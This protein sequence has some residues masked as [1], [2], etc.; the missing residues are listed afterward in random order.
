M[1]KKAVQTTRTRLI[2]DKG[3]NELEI[4]N[5]FDDFLQIYKVLLRTF[6]F[7]YY[8]LFFFSASFTAI[9]ESVF[10]IFVF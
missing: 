10:E 2:E 7:Y 4:S 8:C 3:Q 5:D 9:S 1:S 6:K